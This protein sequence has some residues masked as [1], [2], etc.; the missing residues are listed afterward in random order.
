LQEEGRRRRHA[1]CWLQRW[2]SETAPIGGAFSA[3]TAK[4]SSRKET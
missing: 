2:W 4:L 3:R 1:C